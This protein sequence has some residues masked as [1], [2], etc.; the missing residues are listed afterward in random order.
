[1]R[2]RIELKEMIRTSF[3]RFPSLALKYLQDG[4]LELGR[5]RRE[6]RSG[7]IVEK[8]RGCGDLPAN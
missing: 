2:I 3:P 6:R 1:M 8:K 5:E 4:R 7:L